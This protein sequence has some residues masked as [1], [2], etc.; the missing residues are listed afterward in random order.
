MRKNI[1]QL[2]GKTIKKFSLGSQH[3]TA[4]TQ[5]HHVFVW[6]SNEYGQIVNS[7]LEST[8]KEC[9]KVVH[10]EDILIEDIC[11]GANHTLALTKDGKVFAWGDNEFGQIGNGKNGEPQKEPLLLNCFN[12]EK[13]KK[14]S[15]GSNHSMALTKSYKVYTWGDNSFGQ[16]GFDDCKFSDKLRLL[17]RAADEFINLACGA[18]HSLLLTIDG[19]IRAFGY[20][21][22]GQV[23]NEK[24]TDTFVPVPIKPEDPFKDIASNFE[25]CISVALTLNKLS[26]FVW[27]ECGERKVSKPEKSNFN[28]FNEIFAHYC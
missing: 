13:V 17:V 21:E 22:Y 14:I 6:G 16:L 2:N 12:D 20:N 23:G 18:K 26:Y 15:C 5:D 9:G 25:C 10:F 1:V 3:S 27:G 24:Y 4:L 11:C 28:S 19:S 8:V 7:K